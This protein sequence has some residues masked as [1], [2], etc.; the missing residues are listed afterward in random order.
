LSFAPGRKISSGGISRGWGSGRRDLDQ[1]VFDVVDGLA[2]RLDHGGAEVDEEL[3]EAATIGHAQTVRQH[4][5]EV[6]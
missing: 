4:R 3:V 6:S 1:L 2:R 5:F